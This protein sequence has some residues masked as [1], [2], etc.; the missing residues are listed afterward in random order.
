MAEVDPMC[1]AIGEIAR[2][3][4][5]HDSYTFFFEKLHYNSVNSAIFCLVVGDVCCL[6]VLHK[7]SG[8]I[9]LVS[10]PH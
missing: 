6:F 3:V 7:S 10:L 5:M 2:N 1:F 8:K 9:I 4:R